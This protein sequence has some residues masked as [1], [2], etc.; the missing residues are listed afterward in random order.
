MTL[1]GP[2]NILL[3]TQGQIQEFSNCFF[4]TH[5]PILID[6]CHVTYTAL[7]HTQFLGRRI[8]NYPTS[9]A[10]AVDLLLV[11]IEY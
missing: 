9:H 3:S 6:A 1:I 10:L 5:V 7:S 11:C 8:K 2:S 4:K